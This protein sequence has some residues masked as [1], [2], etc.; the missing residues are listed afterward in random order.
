MVVVVVVK[1]DGPKQNA[2]QKNGKQVVSI[3]KEGN[4]KVEGSG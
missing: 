2:R 3:P 1:E 4:N